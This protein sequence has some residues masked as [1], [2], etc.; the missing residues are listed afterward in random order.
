MSHGQPSRSPPNDYGNDD[1]DSC[2]AKCSL[3]SY[4]VL[5]SP[6]HHPIGTRLN[7]MTENSFNRSGYGPNQPRMCECISLCRWTLDVGQSPRR[8]LR[9]A[10][11]TLCMGVVTEL[12]KA[13]SSQCCCI[14]LIFSFSRVGRGYHPE[15][16]GGRMALNWADRFILFAEWSQDQRHL[17]RIVGTFCSGVVSNFAVSTAV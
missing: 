6:V 10:P 16:G 15:G 8:Q 7:Q 11:Y 4:T 17:L 13:R 1:S 14:G 2:Q 12:S 5:P 3:P 9:P